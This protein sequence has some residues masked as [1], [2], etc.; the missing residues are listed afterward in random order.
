MPRLDSIRRAGTQVSD[1]ALACVRLGAGGVRAIYISQ[2]GLFGRWFNRVQGAQGQRVQVVG[3]TGQQNV[4]FADTGIN[5]RTAT[6]TEA[7]VSDPYPAYN[8][9]LSFRYS[10]WDVDSRNLGEQLLRVRDAI[11]IVEDYGGKYWLVGEDNGC[12]VSTSAGTEAYG[13]ASAITVT[14]TCSQRVPV[15]QVAES[16]IAAYVT[17]PVPCICDFTIEEICAIGFG[18]F[19]GYK[20]TCYVPGPP[21]PTGLRDQERMAAGPLTFTVNTPAAGLVIQWSLTNT[22]STIVATGTTYTANFPIGTTPVY[23]RTFSP[24]TGRVSAVIGADAVAL[25]FSFSKAIIAD[26]VNDYIQLPT[27]I[28]YKAGRC[29]TISFW[30]KIPTIMASGKDIMSFRG[31]LSTG[32]WTISARRTTSSQVAYSFIAFDTS[33]NIQGANWID[34]TN[35]SDW[36]HVCFQRYTINGIT[37]IMA[38]VNGILK[39]NQNTPSIGDVDTSANGINLFANSTGTGNFFPCIFDELLFFDRGLSQ[40]DVLY[41]YSNGLGNFPDINGLRVR[42]SFDNYTGAL[43]SITIPDDSF[44]GYDA[45]GFNFSTNPLTPH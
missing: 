12:V 13:G 9:T 30:I 1:T 22:F 14:A 17:A 2:R 11:F 16:Y 33:F 38:Y 6:L 4:W 8:V 5:V 45:T 19:C 23:V 40:Q 42:Y 31:N 39:A 29:N 15:R 7:S 37:T 24:D 32:Y 21:S 43:P 20:S 41:L 18:E 25:A 10:G 27:G 3:H 34:T 36:S 26:G 28:S 35:Q 44:S